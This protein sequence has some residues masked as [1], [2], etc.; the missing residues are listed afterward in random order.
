MGACVLRAMWVWLV[1][2]LC[3]VHALAMAAPRGGPEPPRTLVR[4]EGVARV[5]DVVIDVGCM[6][7]NLLDGSARCTLAVAASIDAIESVALTL[8][9]EADVSL[10]GQRVQSS[11]RIGDGV[12]ARITIRAS[13]DLTESRDWSDAPWIL[14][15]VHS[16][17]PLLGEGPSLRVGGDGARIE[18]IDGA[19]VRFEGALWVDA[20]RVGSVHARVGELEVDDAR[21]LAAQRP[22]I[23]LGTTPRQRDDEVMQHGGPVL[24]LGSRLS[25][26]DE[27]SERFLVRLSYEA[28][29]FEHALVAVGVETDGRSFLAS[30][31]LAVGTPLVA[32]FLPS[33][34]GGVGIVARQ[35]EENRADAG[36][37]LRLDATTFGAGFGVDVDYF[38]AT[39]EWWASSTIRVGL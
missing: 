12:S 15:A 4:V 38:P 3:P 24:A 2:L 34:A 21:S 37:R 8:D 19:H 36:L 20:R 27:S 11:A 18:A 10:D 5:Y 22:S 32:I 35:E 14:P 23:A 16:R 6:G 17:H 28:G 39:G 31:G 7:T 9:A 29:L 26:A 1:A 13:V 30:A 25:L 33:V